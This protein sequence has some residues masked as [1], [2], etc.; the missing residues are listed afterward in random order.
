MIYVLFGL[1][2][3]VV[4]SIVI[5]SLTCLI[6]AINMT[7]SIIK[8]IN[9]IKSDERLATGSYVLRAS[10]VF[11]SAIETFSVVAEKKVSLEREKWEVERTAIERLTNT[12]PEPPDDT[13][14]V[15][16]G[17]E[18]DDFMSAVIKEHP[19]QARV[20]GAEQ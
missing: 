17:A 9:K 1:T 18:L 13:Q 8:D 14:E 20:E 7:S 5:A 11:A 3:I 16:S 15:T 2:T 19:E 12:K 4:Y 6:F 10:G